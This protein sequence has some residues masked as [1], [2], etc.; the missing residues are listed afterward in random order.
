MFTGLWMAVGSTAA[1]AVQSFL[2]GPAVRRLG[3]RTTLAIGAA[4]L[5]VSMGW[6]GVAPTGQLYMCGMLVGCLGGLII[7]GLQGLMTRRVGPTQQGQLQGANQSLIGIASMVG[8]LLFGLSFAAAVRHPG[9]GVP[10][11]PMLLASAIMAMCFSLA[12]YAGRLAGKA[13]PPPEDGDVAVT[14]TVIGGEV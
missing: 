1:I 7:P 4:A 13:S 2:V 5:T 11:L 12:I 6:Y 10:G 8:P 9:W 14:S 3:E